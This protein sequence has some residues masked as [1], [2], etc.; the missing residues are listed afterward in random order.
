M[1][2]RHRIKNG[3]KIR[4]VASASLV[5]TFLTSFRPLASSGDGASSR[6]PNDRFFLRRT[7]PQPLSSGSNEIPF[8]FSANEVVE[9]NMQVLR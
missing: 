1:G 7:T 4:D 3:Q 6:R 2:S 8:N 5:S 9:D